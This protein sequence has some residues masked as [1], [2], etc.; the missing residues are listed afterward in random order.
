MK[1]EELKVLAK[2]VANEAHAL[3]TPI[4]FDKLVKDGVLMRTGKSYYTDNVRSLPEHVAKKISSIEQTKK[5]TK[6]T[7]Y[8]ETKSMKKVAEDFK[9]WRE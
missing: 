7:F 3:A 6:L 9:R 8:K 5:G 2:L 1:E 4:D